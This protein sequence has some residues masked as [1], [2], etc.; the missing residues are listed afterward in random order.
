M[1]PNKYSF[2]RHTT[3]AV[4]LVALVGC[5]AAAPAATQ[6]TT[7]TT[8]VVTEESPVNVTV[9]TESAA[10]ERETE[11]VASAAAAVTADTTIVFGDS[12]LIEGVGAEITEDGVYITDSGTYALS[13]AA[14]DTIVVVDAADESV[15]LLLDGVSITNSDGPAILFDNTSESNVV[16]VEGT[17]NYLEDGD[18]HD[19]N[20]ATLW[21]SATLNISGGGDLT[22]V[23]HYQEGIASEMHMNLN[24]GNIWVT[25]YD[26]GLNA[27]ND[28][29]SIITIND[30]FLHINAGG[31]GIDSNGT[32]V[33]NGGVVISSSALTDMSGGM[34][35][36]GAVTI[37]GGT[38]IVTG[39]RNSVPVSTS[40]QKSL[41]VNY[42][43][44]QAA[45]T[46][47][48]IVDAEGNPIVIFAPEVAYQELV[49]STP[50]IVEGVTYTVYSGGTVE[51]EALNGWYA[52]GVYTPGTQ[53]MTVDTTSVQ[54][55]GGPGGP[56]G[57]QPPTRP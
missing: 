51:G 36:D 34:D 43:S 41:V 28:G 27:N 24:G 56:G 33:M 45:G 17:T 20:D 30:G 21:S 5:A 38:L 53:V 49:V 10:V 54:N 32:V 29:V 57:A 35:A 18:E 9:A 13:G 55:A 31:D 42:G 8:E 50:D 22:V 26:D 2:L 14:T 25:S 48:A 1:K 52:N 15:T 3:L 6:A 4:A 44:T 46:L 37:N 47:T 40:A 11:T 7:V 16:I 23:G 12:I 19:D 39:A